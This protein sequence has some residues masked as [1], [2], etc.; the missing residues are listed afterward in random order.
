MSAPRPSL[1]HVDRDGLRLLIDP[2]PTR[3][4]VAFTDRIGGSSAAPY[5]SLNL[6]AT[7]GDDPDAVRRNRE[8]VARAAG[9][10]VTSL[11]LARQVHGAD[12][13]HVTSSDPVVAGE[14]DV[15]MTSEP[16]VS[17]GI[18]TADCTPVVVAGTAVVAIAHAG[19]RGLVAGAVEAAVDAVGEVRAAWVGP[20]IHACCYEVGPEVIAAFRDRG[21]PVAGVDRV[22]PGRA[23][24]FALHRAGVERV[25]ASVDCTSCDRRYFSYRRDGTTGRQGAFVSLL[26]Q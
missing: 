15:L 2:A 26:E 25:A 4:A 11:R 5:D 20:S 24:T 9:F 3:C 1:A 6:A 14:G 7:V 17:L 10:A 22:D 13:L 18:L 16:G 23:A 21:L 8:R 12:I 19:W